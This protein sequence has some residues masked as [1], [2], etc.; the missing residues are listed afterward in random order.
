V[1]P[2][3]PQEAIDADVEGTVT[4]QAQVNPQGKVVD[5]K[6]LKSIPLLDAAAITAVKQWE[7]EPSLTK[8]GGDSIPVSVTVIVTVT[9]KLR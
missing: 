1:P 2:V 8:V 3:Y 7:Y 9:F 5:A 4:L 6:V